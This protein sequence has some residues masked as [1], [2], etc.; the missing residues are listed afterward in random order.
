MV[1]AETYIQQG[2]LLVTEPLRYAVVRYPSANLSY[3]RPL[4]TAKRI[5]PELSKLGEMVR[6]VDE[7]RT[8]KCCPSCGEEMEKTV[9]VKRPQETRQAQSKWCLNR[10]VRK[11]TLATRFAAKHGLPDPPPAAAPP[12]PR[13]DA[14]YPTVRDDG[15]P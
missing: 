12:P 4:S 3:L 7:H 13:A 14:T 15:A 10:S 11:A 8:S 5:F 6:W 1:A 2:N 9:L